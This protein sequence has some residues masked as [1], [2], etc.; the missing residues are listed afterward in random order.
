MKIIQRA[1]AILGF[2]KP[3]TQQRDFTVSELS[4]RSGIPLAT[5]HRL[6]EAMARVNMVVQDPVTK[7]WR[8][9]VALIELGLAVIE[10]SDVRAAARPHMHALATATQQPSYLTLV[11]GSD[12]VSVERVDIPGLTRMV[13]VIGV[14]RPLY[15]GAS[16]KVVLAFMPPAEREAL[17]P[18]G[19]EGRRLNTELEA[20]RRQG[21][22]FTVA[23]VSDWTAGL[24]APVRDA[25][26]RVIG[27]IG[28][29]GA[30]EHFGSEPPRSFV[31]QVLKAA[32]ETSKDM[33][34]PGAELH[35]VGEHGG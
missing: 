29:S 2:M 8:L 20:I 3:N 31:D 15:Q 28:I 35:R 10:S 23:E 18:D 5:V 1:A 13:E 12:A 26:G 11:V 19:E 27:S 25:R 6:L 30:K 9:G 17:L 21:Y 33:G 14:R 22:A 7:R 32:W 34:W 4:A 24:F 16:R